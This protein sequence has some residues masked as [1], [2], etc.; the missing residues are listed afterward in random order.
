MPPFF[1][2]RLDALCS[3]AQDKRKDKQ[4][5]TTMND[6]QPLCGGQLDINVRAMFLGERID[7]RALES[8]AR[9]ASAPLTIRAGS[10]GCAVLFRH[11]AVVLFGMEPM[12][13]VAFLQQLE[14]LVS[15]PFDKIETEETRL[16]VDQAHPDN[17]AHGALLVA[18]VTVERL[19]LVAEALAKSVALAYYESHVSSVFDRVEPLAI[20]L[21]AKGRSSQRSRELLQYIGDALRIQHRTIGRVEIVDK[22]ELLWEHPEL[23]RFYHRLTDEYELNERQRALDNKLKV[24]SDIAET[25]LDLLHNRRSLRVEW[26]IT[27]L[28]VFEILLTLYEMF[29]RH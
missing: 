25:L 23:E 21:Q 2:M 1:F 10:R 28:I 8:A 7:L 16:R 14:P 26:Y 11:G 13:E 5:I 9:L 4:T 27:I 29:M 24:I 17:I 12:E 15:S 22:P 3:A 18:T 6:E 20:E 19:Q